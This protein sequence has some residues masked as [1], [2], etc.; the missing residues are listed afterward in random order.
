MCDLVIKNG[1]VIDGTGAPAVREDIAIKNGIIVEKGKSLSESSQNVIDADGLIIA[2]GFIDN[3]THSDAV[4]L[5]NPTAEN[6]LL[7]GVTTEI[8]G[9]C[10][11]S[12]FPAIDPDIAEKTMFTKMVSKETLEKYKGI[13]TL[14]QFFDHIDSAGNGTNIAVYT[15]H[16]FLRITAMGFDDRDPTESEMAAMK[17]L[18]AACMKDGSLGLSSG[19]IYPPGVF[20]KTGEL[21]ELCKEAAKYGGNYATH[22]R[23]EGSDVVESVEEAITIARTAKI[24]LNISHLKTAGRKNWGKSLKLLEMIDK[25]NAE[26]IEVWADQ[27]PFKASTTNLAV[28]IP[29]KYL[30]DGLSGLS[31]YLNDDKTVKELFQILSVYSKT[32][33]WENDLFYTEPGDIMI[34]SNIISSGKGAFTL[35]EY[36][37]Q[38][39]ITNKVE[40][41]LSVLKKDVYAFGVFFEMSEDDIENI[42]KHPLVAVGTDGWTITSGTSYLPPRAYSAFP[43]VIEHYVGERKLF[44]LEECIRKITYFPASKA[45]IKSKGL[46]AEGMDADITIFDNKRIK[47]NATFEQPRLPNDGIE[48]VIIGG[49]VVVRSGKLT[50]V[51]AGRSVRHGRN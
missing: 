29:P 19:L 35:A 11:I 38:N 36:M 20:A 13:K 31:T 50:G 18:L 34:F 10:G 45:R 9:Q 33:G 25:A 23:N 43:R 5:D 26:G 1:M 46:I 16:N 32:T 14:A 42:M 2:P 37:K 21:V 4:C 40:A 3:H 48:Y 27:Y 8:T 49:K 24:P 22:I 41:V 28:Y 44:T 7:Q 6:S 12:A 47:A 15:G 17:N 30:N 39:G 51:L